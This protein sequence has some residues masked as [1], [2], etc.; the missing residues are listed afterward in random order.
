MDFIDLKT[1]YKKVENKIKR[2]I[3]NIFSFK[4]LIKLID[5]DMLAILPIII[6]ILK[7]RINCEDL[8]KTS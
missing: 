4:S 6:K 3:S 8:K 1:Q 5:I 7:Y 2:G